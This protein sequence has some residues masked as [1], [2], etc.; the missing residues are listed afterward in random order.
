M[1]QLKTLRSL[2]PLLRRPFLDDLVSFWPGAW[3]AEENN[4]APGRRG[5]K[6][7]RN[8]KRTW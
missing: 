5:P 3:N 7:S 1:T 2:A 6:S 4:A 8:Q